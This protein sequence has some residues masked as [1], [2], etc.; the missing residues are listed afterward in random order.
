[1]GARGCSAS[2]GTIVSVVSRLSDKPGN[3]LLRLEAP[4]QRQGAG[5][6]NFSRLPARGE[7]FLLTSFFIEPKEHGSTESVRVR[8][9]RTWLAR[10]L[11]LCRDRVLLRYGPSATKQLPSLQGLT[12][13]LALL[14]KSEKV[15]S[16]FGHLPLSALRQV[17]P[18]FTMASG[19]LLRIP[20]T[21]GES[22]LAVV[23]CCDTR[24]Y[25]PLI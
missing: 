12:F 14:C 13:V 1:M 4:A 24:V 10:P 17:V 18:R 5:C 20:R 8:L 11:T 21:L 25:L 3:A 9:E 22:H 16:S 7:L 19:R 6:R 15:S 23:G 2:G